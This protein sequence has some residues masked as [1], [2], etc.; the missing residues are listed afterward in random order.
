[1]GVVKEE[2]AELALRNARCLC[3]PETRALGILVARATRISGRGR[4][5]ATLSGDALPDDLT[6][7]SGRH[8]SSGSLRTDTSRTCKT[9]EKSALS[10]IS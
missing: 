7:A 1:M 6:K 3:K 9:A 4:N 10:G 2:E 5:V 8:L